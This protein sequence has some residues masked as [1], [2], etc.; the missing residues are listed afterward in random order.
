MQNKSIKYG[1]HLLSEVTVIFLLALPIANSLSHGIYYLLFL[2]I[3]VFFII[4]GRWV[5]DTHT[6]FFLGFVPVFIFYFMGFPLLHTF[7]LALILT[8]RFAMIRR[9]TLEYP[10]I[11]YLGLTVI[12]MIFNM[13]QKN[14]PTLIIYLFIQ[15]FVVSIGS[16]LSYM[17]NMKST[18]HYVRYL[19]SYIGLLLSGSVVTLIIFFG[20]KK[21][22]DVV[23]PYLAMA[24]G[25]IVGI[26]SFLDSLFKDIEIP[27]SEEDPV[28]FEPEEDISELPSMFDA[29][30]P[31]LI[32]NFIII[33]LLILFVFWLVLKKRRGPESK[34]RQVNQPHVIE[35]LKQKEEKNVSRLFNFLRRKPVHPVRKAVYDLE[36]KALKH[37]QGRL[38]FE[39]V[40]EWF[41]RLEIDLPSDIYQMIRYGDIDVD[42]EKISLFKKQIKEAERKI[43]ANE[44]GG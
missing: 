41:E 43:L 4:L 1:S 11:I 26:F 5:G 14:D 31:G 18:K 34:I 40:D 21:I 27:E 15:F 29:L 8:W 20:L 30:A 22:W 12:L 38:P 36:R 25:H 42:R 17:T 28:V 33:G 24:L 16:A 32:L 37:G 44:S 7:I 39:T 6:Y 13:I 35:P 10:E 23:F 3:W 9:E 19:L 2:A